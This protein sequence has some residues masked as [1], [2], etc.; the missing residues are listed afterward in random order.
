[1]PT[2]SVHPIPF[3]GMVSGRNVAFIKGFNSTSP[4]CINVQFYICILCYFESKLCKCRERVWIIIS[5]IDLEL[6]MNSSGK[7]NLFFRWI[8]GT[9]PSLYSDIHII[10]C[11]SIESNCTGNNTILVVIKILGNS[12]RVAGL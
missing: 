1:M 9:I 3:N 2:I 4:E 5:I 7:T 12:F 8:V 10:I 11:R 6:V